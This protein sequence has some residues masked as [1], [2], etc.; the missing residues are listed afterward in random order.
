MSVSCHFVGNNTKHCVK[1]LTAFELCK[2]K[3]NSSSVIPAT[4]GTAAGILKFMFFRI[5]QKYSYAKI[6]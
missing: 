4:S 1:N 2:L 5:M 3:K 6:T